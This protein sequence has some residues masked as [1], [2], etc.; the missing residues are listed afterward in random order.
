MYG[1][2]CPKPLRLFLHN[3]LHSQLSPRCGAVTWVQAMGE[4]D[5]CAHSRCL[6]IVVLMR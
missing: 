3:L 2:Q 6:V 5:Q 4:V 1:S